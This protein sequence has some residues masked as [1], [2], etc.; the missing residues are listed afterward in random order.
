MRVRNIALQ[1]MV[2]LPLVWVIVISVPFCLD[3]VAYS[4]KT[5]CPSFV[6]FCI[7]LGPIPV[8][9]GY[10]ADP[11]GGLAGSDDPLI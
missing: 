1:T 8:A 11:K 3:A 9:L 4:S 6:R 5:T 7:R 2:I 10:I